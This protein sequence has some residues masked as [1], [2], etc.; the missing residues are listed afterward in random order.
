MNTALQ[1]SY[2]NSNEDFDDIHARLP[3]QIFHGSTWH[4]RLLPSMHK[5][6]YPYRYWGVNISAL[7]AGQ[8]LPEVNI[9]TSVFSKSKILKKLLLFSGTKKALQQFHP[10]DYLPGLGL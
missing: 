1:P 5:F 10:N 6:A 7:A 2:I 8:P 9:N 3:H 4:S